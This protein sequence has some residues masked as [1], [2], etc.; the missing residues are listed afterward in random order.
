MSIQSLFECDFAEISQMFGGAEIKSFL[1]RS[2]LHTA[3]SKNCLFSCGNTAPTLRPSAFLPTNRASDNDLRYHFLRHPSVS[4]KPSRTVNCSP[5]L[6]LSPVLSKN[7]THIPSFP[8][9]AFSFSPNIFE[10]A[11]LTIRCRD[12]GQ[13]TFIE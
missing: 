12:N 10:T 11:R 13:Q 4:F 5:R 2:L 6:L 7:C 9:P 3:P 1:S 8:C